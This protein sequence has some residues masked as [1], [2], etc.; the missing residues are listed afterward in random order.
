M[1]AA[2]GETTSQLALPKMKQK[3]IEDVTG[4]RVLQ[5][6]NSY[7]LSEGIFKQL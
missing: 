5:W 6:D 4:R 1:V 3:M 2:L 7:F